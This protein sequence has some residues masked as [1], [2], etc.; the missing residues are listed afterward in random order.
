MHAPIAK[1]QMV[2]RRPIGEV[3]EA[4][5]DP[6]ITSRFWFSRSTGRMAVGQTVRWDWDMYGVSTNV[7]V[8]AVERNRRILIE[9]DGPDN[10][11]SVEWRFERIAKD[12]TL[13]VIRNW[14]FRGDAEKIVADAINSSGGFS[15]VL[16]GLKAFVEHQIDLRLVQDHDPRAHVEA[17]ASRRTG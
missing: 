10:T 1:A 16:A 12:R 6:A 11:S 15:F 3:F 7:D 5:V 2:I 4:F 14:G 8:K 17:T 9:W 13:V